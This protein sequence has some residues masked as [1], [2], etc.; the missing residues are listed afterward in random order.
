MDFNFFKK[1]RKA[2]INV[3]LIIALISG[4][5]SSVN[6]KQLDIVL[7]NETLQ[8]AIEMINVENIKDKGFNVR[9]NSVVGVVDGR[10]LLGDKTRDEFLADLEKNPSKYENIVNSKIINTIGVRAACFYYAD[11]LKNLKPNELII[12][13]DSKNGKIGIFDCKLKEKV[14]YETN[15]K[16]NY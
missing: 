6:A 16:A 11:A 5:S 8:P 12:K 3:A 13:I 7:N 10:K 9:L 1:F 4:I 15:I 2:K 14:I